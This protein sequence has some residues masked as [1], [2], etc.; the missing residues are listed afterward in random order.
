MFSFAL[1]FMG[2]DTLLS[3][4]TLVIWDREDGS[5]PEEPFHKGSLCA[6]V[7]VP[8]NFQSGGFVIPRIFCWIFSVV[9]LACFRYQARYC[10]EYSP[11]RSVLKAS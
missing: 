8:C 3:L 9:F 7:L 6:D 2:L 5:S 4:I 10:S 1:E 11:T